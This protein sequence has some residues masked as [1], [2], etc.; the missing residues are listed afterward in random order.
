MVPAA[1]QGPNRFG[2]RQAVTFPTAG[3]CAARRRGTR[4]HW[5]CWCCSSVAALLIGPSS[6]SQPPIG[7]VLP[8]RL[9]SGSACSDPVARVASDTQNVGKEWAM[10]RRLVA[11]LG[12]LAVAAV[13]LAVPAAAAGGSSCHLPRFVSGFYN[14][15]EPAPSDFCPYTTVSCSLDAPRAV[16]V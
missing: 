10:R 7:A 6:P 2:L 9:G 5:S 1:D 3:H 4:P 16:L 15:P 11:I 13:A 12:T 14:Q 8:F